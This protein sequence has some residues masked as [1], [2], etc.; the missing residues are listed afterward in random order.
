MWVPLATWTERANGNSPAMFQGSVGSS[1]RRA[2]HQHT[3]AGGALGTSIGKASGPAKSRCSHQ[4]GGC[5][6]FVTPK[7]AGVLVLQLE[8][9]DST[10]PIL[11]ASG[12]LAPRAMQ[13]VALH[14]FKQKQTYSP[15]CPSPTPTPT[16]TRS[17]SVRGPGLSAKDP[18]RKA[19]QAMAMWEKR[20]RST[21]LISS[22]CL[23]PRRPDQQNYRRNRRNRRTEGNGWLGSVH[24]DR[25]NLKPPP[26]KNGG[27]GWL[28]GGSPGFKPR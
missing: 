5:P 1:C 3:R 16:P 15:A 17:F 25:T 7:T 12:I 10:S 23:S 11:F 9:H 20:Q 27:A 13:H 2:D 8:R 18:L 24:Q 21:M 26:K 4:F 28:W 6:K 19:A 14:H 22:V